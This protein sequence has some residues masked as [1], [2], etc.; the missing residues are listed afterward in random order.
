MDAVQTKQALL[1]GKRMRRPAD[2]PGW[3]DPHKFI[4]LDPEAAGVSVP[5]DRKLQYNLTGPT[6]DWMLTHEDF[7]AED[8]YEYTGEDDGV[9][10]Y[11]QSWTDTSAGLS[12]TAI[13]TGTNDM[14][15]AQPGT[16]AANDSSTTQGRTMAYQVGETKTLNVHPTLKGNPGRIERII[17]VEIAPPEAVSVVIA[18]DGQSAALTF[19]VEA[20]G[21]TGV[22]VG[23]KNPNPDKVDE[24]AANFG[25]FDILAA[26]VADMMTATLD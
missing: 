17:R 10:E 1:E 12:G 20:S 23:D 19:L 3:E 5:T 4:Y 7:L 9:A 21:V 11:S 6:E 26:E 16:T 8:W 25:P 24:L 18:D 15:V 22:V 2:K 14:A 13:P